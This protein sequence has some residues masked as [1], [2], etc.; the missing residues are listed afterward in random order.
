MGN[1]IGLDFVKSEDVKKNRQKQI[2]AK[3]QFMVKSYN[4]KRQG[5]KQE[6]LKKVNLWLAEHVTK[7][8]EE[9]NALE[10]LEANGV[11]KRRATMIG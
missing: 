1:G 9:P 7:I 10:N 11:L 8:F 3:S 6:I 5:I 2:M 4:L